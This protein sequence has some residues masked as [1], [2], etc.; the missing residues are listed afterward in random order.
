M[1]EGVRL[2]DDVCVP[3]VPSY[4]LLATL[5]ANMLNQQ[6]AELVATAFE[7]VRDGEGVVKVTYCDPQALTECVKALVS[8]CFSEASEELAREVTEAIDNDAL[9]GALESIL[10]A[11]ANAKDVNSLKASATVTAEVGG[12]GYT[13]TDMKAEAVRAAKTV[14][15]GYAR[16]LCLKGAT[17]F[18]VAVQEE[19]VIDSEGAPVREG[20]LT[21]GVRVDARKLAATLLNPARLMAALIMAGEVPLRAGD[22]IPPEEEVADSINTS[23]GKQVCKAYELITGKDGTPYLYSE[24]EVAVYELT[25]EG[26]RKVAGI[27]EIAE[28]ART[29]RVGKWDVAP[30]ALQALEEYLKARKRWERLVRKF[31]SDAI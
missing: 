2:G 11:L 17:Q 8:R 19:Y 30:H 7:P 27:E 18:K 16:H 12:D 9:A 23:C 29:G 5:G 6:V 22:T 21:I 1:A 28:Y 24:E 10:K 4:A 13:L 31:G 3:D 15:D 20:R 26:L 14:M 25:N